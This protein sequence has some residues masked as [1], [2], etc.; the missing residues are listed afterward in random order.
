MLL[1]ARGAEAVTEFGLGVLLD[2][3]F[4]LLPEA[5][6]VANFFAGRT[7]GHEPLQHF[8]FPQG[9]LQLVIAAAR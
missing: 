2:I 7:D 3:F 5:L 4:Q 1:D 8:H 6:V 9:P